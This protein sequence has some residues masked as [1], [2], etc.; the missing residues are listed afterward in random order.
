MTVAYPGGIMYANVRAN[1]RTQPERIDSSSSIGRVMARTKHATLKDVAAHVGVSYQTVSKVLAGSGE[2][3]EGTRQRILQAVEE[4]GYRPNAIAR[5]LKTKRTEIIGLIVPNVLSPAWSVMTRGVED[6][7][8]E[9][10]FQTM[11]CDT[12][13]K[14]EVEKE[15]IATLLDRRVDG[16]ILAS[17]PKPSEGQL[18]SL[19][20][21]GPPVVLLDR[22]VEGVKTDTVV[23]DNWTGAYEATQHLLRA[24]RK[25]IGIITLSLDISTGRERL[26]GYK[27]ALRD[28]GAAVDED[29]TAVGG[30]LFRDGYSGVFTLW[31]RGSP[32]DALLICSHGMTIGVLAALKEIKVKVPRDVAIVGFDDPPWAE[33]LD[34]SLTV[35]A[36]PLYEMAT[37]ATRLLLERIQG[38]ERDG[39]AKEVVLKSKLIV[40]KSS[41]VH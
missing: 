9:S 19:L 28:S 2:V 23:S 6:A 26:E 21:L 31:K 29:L 38:P 12:D 10:G 4:T 20:Q 41:G 37:T 40:R 30:S 34:P 25:R 8:A 16:L 11:I 17:C 24:G 3:S 35:V 15:S 22:R 18:A 5:S 27:A 36:Q 13:E 32:P 39:E 7:A 1:V 33:F 14:W